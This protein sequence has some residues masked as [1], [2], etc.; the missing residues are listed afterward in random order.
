[1]SVPA[2]QEKGIGFKLG[3]VATT[4]KLDV[5]GGFFQNQRYS[6][7]IMISKTKYLFTALIFLLTVQ[8]F[9]QE[10]KAG[11][12]LEEMN[13]DLPDETQ[14][15]DLV[16]KG[17]WQ[18]ETGFLL[19]RYKNEPN[20]YITQGLLRYGASKNIELKLLIEDGR[21]RDRYMQKTVQ[22]TYPLAL[23]TKI[24]LV[25]DHPGLPDM[26]FVSFVKLPFT[27]QS[28]ANKA[29]WSPIF[30]MAFQNKFGEKFKLEYNAGIQQEAYSSE[31]FW[32]VNASL[33]YKIIEKLEIFTEYYAQ[34]I[35]HEQPSHNLGGG[36]AYQLNN[37]L[38]FYLSTGST[39]YDEDQ[40][41]FFNG[42]VAFR[43]P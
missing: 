40:N 31:W 24:L 15:T 23:G 5:K 19:N 36:I 43:L 30:L 17:H 11:K 18:L 33:H 39:I 42:G 34:Y 2:G 10:Q 22:S 14:E 21:G 38:E 7:I 12:P 32:L 29:Y 41:H 26:T 13:V 6:I 20:S 9:S 1:M 4:K 25:K 27:S 16:D 35:N 8:G 28:S 37:I 3:G